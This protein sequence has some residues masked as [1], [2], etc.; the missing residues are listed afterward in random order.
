MTD[1][2][3]FAGTDYPVREL[4]LEEDGFTV[5]IVGEA[6]EDVLLNSDGSYVSKEARLIDELIFF[7]LPDGLLVDSAEEEIREFLYANL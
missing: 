2:I 7:Y 1:Q 4:W 3:I 5:S 6:L